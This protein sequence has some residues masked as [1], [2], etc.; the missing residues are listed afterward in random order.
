[1][2]RFVEIAK[3]EGPLQD[4]AVLAIGRIGGRDKRHSRRWRTAAARLPRS[5]PWCCRGA[6]CLLGQNCATQAIG[7]Q[8][9]RRSVS[10]RTRA[11]GADPCGGCAS[12]AR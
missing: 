4:D 10:P 7:A 12:L 5:Q 1:M 9:Q 8:S 3:I 11:T 6:S 2:T